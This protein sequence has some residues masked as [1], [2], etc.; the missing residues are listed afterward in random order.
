MSRALLG[1][2]LFV[3]F[4]ALLVLAGCSTSDAPA[5]T[6]TTTGCTGQI[7]FRVEDDG[8]VVVLGC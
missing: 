1:A 2:A 8:S 7:T 5:P 3:L 4:A 6:T